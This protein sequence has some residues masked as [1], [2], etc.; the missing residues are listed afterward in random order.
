MEPTRWSCNW[1]KLPSTACTTTHYGFGPLRHVASLISPR[2][3]F[4]LIPPGYLISGIL[5]ADVPPGYLTSDACSPTFHPDI[6]HPAPVRRRSTRMSHSHNS[7]RPTF[8]LL[9]VFHIRRLPPAAR[10]ERRTIQLP[11][12]DMSGFFGNAYP[13]CALD[14]S[15]IPTL[16]SWGLNHQTSMLF[17]SFRLG[18]HG[19]K[20]YP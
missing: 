3:K 1:P 20:A 2:R 5:S 12:A 4:S 7:I 6:S 13:E 10:W 8:H 14:L 18:S 19:C 11:R 15:A 17:L 9:R 16:S